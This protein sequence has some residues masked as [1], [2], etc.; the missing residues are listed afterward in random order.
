GEWQITKP[1]PMR[2]DG[3]QVDDLIRKLKDAKMDLTAANYDPKVAAAQFA[4]GEKVG[5]ASTTDNLGTQTVE[6]HK[7]KDAKD[8]KASSYYAKSSAV[9]GIYK[10]AGALGDSLGKSPDDYRNKKLFDFGF[11]DP[12]KLEINGTA[13]QKAGDK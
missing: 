11:N 4:S 7:S 6:I 10:V 9:A 5:T 8:D 13:Y 1:K 3:L 2:A 12:S